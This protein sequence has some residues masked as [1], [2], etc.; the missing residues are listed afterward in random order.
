M[1]NRCCER[2]TVDPSEAGHGRRCQCFSPF[3]GRVGSN[4]APSPALAR[5]ARV[6]LSTVL[7]SRRLVRLRRIFLA[8]FLPE[9][10]DDGRRTYVRTRALSN[11]ENKP[12]QTDGQRLKDYSSI[13]SS[14]LTFFS[15]PQ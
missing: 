6:L 4:F 12:L 15:Q 1:N 3:F 9:R 7:I 10:M 5:C 14:S 11:I 13:I 8:R 2:S